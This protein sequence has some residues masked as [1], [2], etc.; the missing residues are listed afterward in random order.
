M[1]R[2]VRRA[3]RWWWWVVAPAAIAVLVIALVKKPARPVETYTPPE[4]QV[5]P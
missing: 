3:H 4:S 1:S 5:Q 2:A